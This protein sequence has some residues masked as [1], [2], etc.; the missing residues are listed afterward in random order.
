M[1]RGSRAEAQGAQTRAMT[2]C[3]DGNGPSE[4]KCSVFSRVKLPKFF[5]HVPHLTCDLSPRRD[6]ATSMLLWLS[7]SPICQGWS[8]YGA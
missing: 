7:P 2:D 1:F 8:R 3:G 6:V 4:P 5:L